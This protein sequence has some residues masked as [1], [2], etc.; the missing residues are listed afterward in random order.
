MRT[1]RFAASKGR[2]S[3]LV[4]AA[5]LACSSC[6]RLLGPD[7]ATSSDFQLHFR[8]SGAYSSVNLVSVQL[9][10]RGRILRKYEGRDFIDHSTPHPATPAERIPGTGD[11]RVT[12]TLRSAVGDTLASSSVSFSLDEQYHYCVDL[13]VPGPRPMTFCAFGVTAVPMRGLAGR[14]DTLFIVAGG[15]PDGAVC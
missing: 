2:Q 14:T 10:N 13:A 3:L 5:S 11:L 8:G 1:W 4:L 12:V 15:L 7:S 9:E 6:N